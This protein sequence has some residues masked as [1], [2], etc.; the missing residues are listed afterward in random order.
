MLVPRFYSVQALF[1]PVALIIT[2]QEER[3]R[4]AISEGWAN[5]DEKKPEEWFEAVQESL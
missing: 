2:A 4:D 1:C 5:V 3:G